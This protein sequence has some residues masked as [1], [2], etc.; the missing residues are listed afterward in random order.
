[1]HGQWIGSVGGDHTGLIILDL[2]DLGTHVGGTAF[3]IETDR[4]FPSLLLKIRTENKDAKQT[5]ITDKVLPVHPNR[6]LLLDRAL[7]ER[8]HL[9]DSIPT[10]VEI[11]WRVSRGKMALTWKS[12]TGRAGFARLYLSR[13]DEPSVLTVNNDIAS[14]DQFKNFALSLPRRHYIFR[15]QDCRKRLRTSFH[16]SRRKDLVAFL[17]RDIPNAHHALTAITKHLFNLRDGDQNGAFL[18]LLQHHGY[19]T[20][21]LDWTYSPF[22]AAFFAYRFRKRIDPAD[23]LVRIFVFDRPAWARLD[24]IQSIAYASPHLSILEALTIENPRAMPQQALSTITN[25]D[26]IENYV[27]LQER[28]M[29]SKYLTA[30]DLPFEERNKVMEDLSLMG[31]TAGSLFPGL[32]GACEELRGRYFHSFN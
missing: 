10:S 31:I 13:A 3:I 28:K 2:D 30:I 27:M 26:D 22:V 12:D 14:W 4:S 11:R 6:P 32:D 25:L 18:N 21:L 9:A 24:S 29:N 7:I 16:R 23:N 19:P 5:I 20:P 17:E 1:M 8:D 15:G